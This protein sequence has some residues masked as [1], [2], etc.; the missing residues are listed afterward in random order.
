MVKKEDYKLPVHRCS[1]EMNC[2]NH[3]N[4]MNSDTQI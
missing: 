2:K 1:C 4:Q 3:V